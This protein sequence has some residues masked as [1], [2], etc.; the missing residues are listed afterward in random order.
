[1]VTFRT[2]AVTEDSSVTLLTEYFASRA[3]SFPAGMGEYRTAFPSPTQFV[4]PRGV[5]LIVQDD[6]PRPGAGDE[7]GVDAAASAPADVGCGGIRLLDHSAGVTRFEVKHLW[8]QPH[9][10]GR[11]FGRLLLEELESRARAFGASEVVL[12]TNVAQEAAAGLYRNAGYVEIAAYNDNP[13][14][15][16]WFAKNLTTELE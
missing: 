15:T 9:L 1:M 4:P 13:N 11:G 8:L 10:R 16:H 6:T 3:Q 12:D 5:F 14:A 2:A 7:N